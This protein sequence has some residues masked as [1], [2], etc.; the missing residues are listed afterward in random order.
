MART[1]EFSCAQC[2]RVGEKTSG[3]VRRSRKI[4]A[5]IYCDRACAG[6][7]RRTDSRTP[8]QKRADK[9]AYDMEYR[10]RNREALKAK[11]AEYYAKVG[12]TQRDRE[13]EVRRKRMPLHV[14][15]CRQPEYRK[16]KQS[17][18]EQRRSKIYGPFAEC[19]RLLVLLKR[20][21][22]NRCPNYYERHTETIK[23]RA[24]NA[25]RRKY[26]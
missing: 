13:R 25:K 22:V 5:P 20:E 6:L 7:A 18:D 9:R 15:Y 3:H 1:L 24:K 21:I 2:G 16:K 23:E 17:Y 10:N 14:E 4:G 26:D 11:H 12:P 19:H 8:E